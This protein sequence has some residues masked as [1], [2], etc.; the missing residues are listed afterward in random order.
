MA[1]LPVDNGAASHHTPGERCS[2]CSLHVDELF[3]ASSQFVLPMRDSSICPFSLPQLRRSLWLNVVDFVALLRMNQKID[4]VLS[5]SVTVHDE[6]MQ[7]IFL[8]LPLQYIQYA[9]KY[10][11]HFNGKLIGPLDA[12]IVLEKH[13]P[14]LEAFLFFFHLNKRLDTMWTELSEPV[15]RTELLDAL[16][17]CYQL[18]LS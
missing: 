2:S 14:K 11:C 6:H 13:D 3:S 5:A 4:S 18:L 1:S 17:R 15:V 9:K 7:T 16:E 12:C 10:T 8:E